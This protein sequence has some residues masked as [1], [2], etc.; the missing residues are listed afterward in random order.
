MLLSGQIPGGQSLFEEQPEPEEEEVVEEELLD[1]DEEL[2]DEV[3]VAEQ[4]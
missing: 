2:D 1:E 3:E 4:G